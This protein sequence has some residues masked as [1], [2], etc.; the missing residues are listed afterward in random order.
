MLAPAVAARAACAVPA[1]LE[2]VDAAFER[3]G[4]PAQR[5][6]ET[7][8]C[9]NCPIWRECLLDAAANGEP[10]PWGGTNARARRRVVKHP[11][12]YNMRNVV[13]PSAA[14]VDGASTHRRERNGE[15]RKVKEWAVST[16]L[17]PRVAKGRAPQWVWD[18]YLE[19]LSSQSAS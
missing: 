5:R 7:E 16:G 14:Q 10:G 11:A 3:Q 8:V 18:A 4:G 13:H 6:M 1:L 12:Y 9:P 15:T 17:L 2:V 19:S